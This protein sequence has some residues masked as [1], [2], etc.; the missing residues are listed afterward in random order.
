MR[1]SGRAPAAMSTKTSDLPRCQQSVAMPSFTEVLETKIF[2]LS[3]QNAY[4]R[5]GFNFNHSCCQ[6][7]TNGVSMV[8]SEECDVASVS[9]E[10]VM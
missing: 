9:C 5:V 3:V 8:R 4:W 10:E 2:K 6:A 7:N 1:G